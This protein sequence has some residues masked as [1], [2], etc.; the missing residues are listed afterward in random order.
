M[1]YIDNI[2]YSTAEAYGSVIYLF[3][4]PNF[5]LIMAANG[6]RSGS[7]K[8]W[9]SCTAFHK[10]NLIVIERI[11]EV[12]KAHDNVCTRFCGRHFNLV[13]TQLNEQG[14]RPSSNSAN[15]VETF[16]DTLVYN[17]SPL[18]FHDF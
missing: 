4:G 2:C 1:V 17:V 10:F 14:C 9:Q 18:P 7:P 5:Q 16:D 8:G 13:V 12:G 15:V 3:N 11:S 6:K